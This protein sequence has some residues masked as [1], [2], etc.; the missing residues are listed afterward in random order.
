VNGCGL[1]TQLLVAARF[2]TELLVPLA[3]RT[4]WPAEPPRFPVRPSTKDQMQ[5]APATFVSAGLNDYCPRVPDSRAF[6]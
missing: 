5:H 6:A 2:A 4:R 3:E 1:S